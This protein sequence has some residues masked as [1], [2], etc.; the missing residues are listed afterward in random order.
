MPNDTSVRLLGRKC[1]AFRVVLAN[2]R[3]IRVS[4]IDHELRTVQ[5]R[6]LLGATIS[7]T[8]FSFQIGSFS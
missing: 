8:C 3:I 4:D 1:I 2:K 7:D 5:C 6:V